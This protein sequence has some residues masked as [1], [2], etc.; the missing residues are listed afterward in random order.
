MKFGSRNFFQV[1]FSS[2]FSRNSFKFLSH[3]LSIEIR[4]SFFPFMR[5]TFQNVLY[6]WQ[7]YHSYCSKIQNFSG[8]ISIIRLDDQ[9]SQ[10]K[11][12]HQKINW[13]SFF[14]SLIV[15]YLPGQGYKERNMETSMVNSSQI[16]FQVDPDIYA[17]R[18]GNQRLEFSIGRDD[19]KQG[20]LGFTI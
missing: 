16:M 11:H 20:A 12:V 14:P 18:D 6:L 13:A 5:L 2:Q 8:P 17:G 3:G 19:R 4:L 15:A 7:S 1:L 9:A 10:S